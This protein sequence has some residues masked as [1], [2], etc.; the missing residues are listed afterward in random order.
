MGIVY[1]ELKEYGK[2]R[3]YLLKC[4]SQY[5]ELPEANYYLALVYGNENN[6]ELKTVY[7]EK[8]K[9]AISTYGMNEDNMCYAYYPYQITLFEI[10]REINSDQRSK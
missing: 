8:A 2:A 3:S 5:K 9:K 4:L 10:Q 1:Y 7:L 6:K